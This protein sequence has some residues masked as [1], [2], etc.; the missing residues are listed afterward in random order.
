MQIE[1]VKDGVNSA[2]VS[3]D[4]PV[5]G[6]CKYGFHID[7]ILTPELRSVIDNDDVIQK[8][9]LHTPEW[10]KRM[11]E[12]RKQNG[13]EYYDDG[14]PKWVKDHKWSKPY[15]VPADEFHRRHEEDY[16]QKT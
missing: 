12:L 9:P 6:V 1:E 16:Y 5:I 8:I 15:L 3:Q 13:L 14:S 4:S 10:D 2:E 7:S 11:E